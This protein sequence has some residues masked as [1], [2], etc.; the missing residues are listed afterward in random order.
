[1]KQTEKSAVERTEY[2]SALVWLAPR[3]T[4]RDREILAGLH[5]HHVMTTHHIHRLYF[6]GAGVRRARRRLLLL[7]RYGLIDRFR[8]FGRIRVPDH[9]VL[10]STGAALV[11]EHRG[12]EPG[13]LGFR[14]DRVLAWAHS[15]RLGHIL[16]LVE[17][18]ALTTEAA[19]ALPAAHLVRWDNE[20]E[21][22]R[23]WGRHIRPDAYMRWHQDQAELDAFWEYDTGSEP[24]TKVRRKMGGYARLARESRLPS[25]VLFAVHSDQREDH[26]AAKLA[27]DVSRQVGAYITTHARLG[28]QGPAEA[29]WRATDAPDRLRLVDITR[30]HTAP[31]QDEE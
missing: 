21:C 23:R 24:L 20:R 15:G 12:M 29:V 16:G 5:D 6:P 18:L 3:V 1:M 14:Q 31:G 19:R 17:C 22:A 28:A 26:L 11:A 9:W 2:G 7:H 25:I 4:P 8:P 13:E 27:D 10:A 30:R